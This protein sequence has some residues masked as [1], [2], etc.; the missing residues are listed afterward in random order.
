MVDTFYTSMACNCKNKRKPNPYKAED[1]LHVHIS[2]RVA[3]EDAKKHEES[4]YT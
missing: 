2:P 4:E 1:T 3:H